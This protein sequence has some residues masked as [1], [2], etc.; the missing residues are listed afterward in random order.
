LASA[1][2]LMLCVGLLAWVY[3]HHRWPEIGRLIPP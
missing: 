3:L 1:S 2:L